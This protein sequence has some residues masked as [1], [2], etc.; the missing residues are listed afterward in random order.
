MLWKFI[1]IKKLLHT[2][3]FEV[4]KEIYFFF[5]L[6]FHINKN[7]YIFIFLNYI[8]MPNKANLFFIFPYM[9]FLSQKNK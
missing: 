3:F 2:K 5:F 1:I 6:D 8:W 9:Y 7:K 4:L